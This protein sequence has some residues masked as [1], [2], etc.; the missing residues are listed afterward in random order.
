[1]I[2]NPPQIHAVENSQILE[3][4]RHVQN[5]IQSIATWQNDE[6]RTNSNNQQ[7]IHLAGSKFIECYL[8]IEEPYDLDLNHLGLTTLPQ[9]I[10]QLRSLQYLN[11][12]DNNISSIPNSISELSNLRNLNISNNAIRGTLPDLSSLNDL[13]IFVASHNYIDEFPSQILNLPSII[14]ISLDYNCITTIQPQIFDL[15]AAKLRQNHQLMFCVSSNNI[16]SIPEELL[17]RDLVERF[18]CENQ[19]PE[20]LHRPNTSRLLT[21]TNDLHSA[22]IAQQPENDAI[23]NII[24]RESVGPGERNHYQHAQSVYIYQNPL[25]AIIRDAG[26]DSSTSQYSDLLTYFADQNSNLNQFFSN[27]LRRSPSYINANSEQK[28]SLAHD[29]LSIYQNIY[30]K[31]DN[32]EFMQIIDN[33]CAVQNCGCVDHYSLSV[34]RLANITQKASTQQLES[35]EPSQLYEYFKNQALFNYFH[36]LANRKIDLIKTSNR[37]FTEDIEVYLNYVR[38]FNNE[39][40]LGLN[41]SMPSI[42]SQSAYQ[43]Q[44]Y[45]PSPQEIGDF[46]KVVSEYKSDNVDSFH[47]IVSS[48]LASNIDNFPEIANLSLVKD[49]K[50]TIEEKTLQFYQKIEALEQDSDLDSETFDSQ[51][52]LIALERQKTINLDLEK[53]F[54]EYLQSLKQSQPKKQVAA[55]GSKPVASPLREQSPN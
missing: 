47:Q 17:Q 7:N 27:F 39:F 23:D 18:L 34:F 2:N 42:F 31:N 26:Y 21:Q 49:F 1:M 50:T 3:N 51:S 32:D 35:L 44:D 24:F 43:G 30:V 45:Q 40:G 55:F 52:K 37:G 33:F 15:I 36:E 16:Q 25:I 4:M 11:C 19:S 8:R 9:A 22:I 6:I 48:Q 54:I 20:N 10:G 53:F 38:I 41:L 5:F 29:L 14:N 46:R 12:S 28:Q 13:R